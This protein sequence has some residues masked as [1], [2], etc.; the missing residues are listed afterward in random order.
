MVSIDSTWR[1]LVAAA[2]ALLG[3]LVTQ[4]AAA[5]TADT[6][7]RLRWEIERNVFTADLPG[8]HTLAVFSLTNLGGKPLPAQGWSIYFTA[9]AGVETGDI[10][11]HARLETLGGTLF[12]LRPTTG[13]QA[14]EPGRTV[15]L[16][17][18]HPEVMSRMDKAPKGPYLVYDAAPDR[19]YA[20]AD[21][22]IV[23]PT[24]PEQLD[25]GPADP[26]PLV[27]PQAIYERNAAIVDIP[28]EQL[29]PV[30][31]TPRQ[32]ERG[33]GR[34]D[35]P[36]MP[37]VLG[38]KALAGEIAAARSLLAPY[39]SVATPQAGVPPLRL[40]IAALAGEG[41]PEAYQ[42]RIDPQAGVSIV[43]NSAAGVAR[44][45]QS[46]R[47]LL[48]L[49]AQ[50]QQGIALPAL[51][52]GDAPRFE[53]RGLQ[54]DV[55]R[56]FQSKATV[57]RLLD[58]MARY[59]LNTLHLH[60]ADDEGWR[61]E[62]PG[63]PELTS[64]GARRGHTATELDHLPPA[65]G[66]GPD[67]GDPHGSGF[68]SRANYIDIVK[69]A[70][71]LRIDVIP[72][73]EMPG[74]ARA[75]VKAMESR[76][77]K[78]LKSDPAAAARYLLSDPDDRS[79][80]RS[81][82]LFSDN[83]INPGMPSTYAFIEKVVAEIAAMHRDAGAP[84]RTIHVGGD[85]LAAGAWEKSPACQALMAKQKLADVEDLWDYFYG[86][87]DAI[88]RAQG[89]SASGWEEL[90]A[91]KTRIHGES[92]LIPNPAFVGRG[93]T[94]YVWNNIAGAEDF[95]YRLANAGYATVLA[96]V[97]NLYF[98]MAYNKNPEEPGH[99]WG[100]YVDLDTVYDFVPLD[101]TRKAATDPTPLPGKD[102]LTDYGKRNIRGLEATLFSETMR[103]PSR[104]DYMLMPRLLG[105]A[106]RAWAPDPA[107]ATERDPGR[108]DRL[109]AA[110]W[111]E[112]VNEV[113][114]RVLPRLDADR[115]GIAY[116]I[117]PP[118]LKLADGRVLANH[119]LPGFVLR[120]TVDG[121]EPG[122][123]SPVVSGPIAAKAVVK[124]AA[125]DRTGRSGRESVIDNR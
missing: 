81:A 57:F 107:W 92:K 122:P 120:Y 99:D 39:F 90:G 16:R 40:S 95:A 69:Y 64:Y 78:L 21:Y 3:I 68:Y 49:Q 46:L 77:R 84:L 10:E 17:F 15:Q 50:P 114:K 124:V 63:I 118:G 28:E 85:E 8:G 117:P 89:L 55:S 34:L 74:H 80:Y 113:G 32:F 116:R 60:L 79:V 13:F 7:L 70:A 18:F 23:E 103:E 109:H 98:D 5:E 73:I 36:R 106:E 75:A 125:F 2:V 97:T 96:P 45:L 94:V 53:Y 112:F 88:L 11:G 58:L 66:S 25:K 51:F 119:Q 24:R 108:A 123:D 93:F 44:G 91:R 71:A 100:A 110:A 56:N 30:F 19:A 61:L 14:L 43:G 35:W 47:Q 12:R 104:I 29:P 22:R 6:T 67:V 20:I 72:E 111:S 65:H 41:S 59:K 33:S 27:T 82:Q 54:L 4:C 38:G 52:I 42:L 101:S 31:P 48:P 105:L 87:V 115:A 83:V 76:R 62:I 121:S 86:R 1:K 26:V 37:E 102:G 9:M